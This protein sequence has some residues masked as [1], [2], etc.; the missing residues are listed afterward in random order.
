MSIFIPKIKEGYFFINRVGNI[1]Y[2]I[3]HNT[4]DDKHLIKSGN[5]YRTE[6]DAVRA[7]DRDYALRELQILLDA[8][9]KEAAF[10]M[11]LDGYFSSPTIKEKFGEEKLR[12]ILEDIK[13]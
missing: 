7:R 6:E 10:S 3:N 12:M 13:C 9:S 11:I 2:K 8:E 1:T 4:V 5:C